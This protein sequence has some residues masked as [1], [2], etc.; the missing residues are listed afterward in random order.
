LFFRVEI[1]LVKSTVGACG[2]GGVTKFNEMP[3]RQL[4]F[5]KFSRNKSSGTITCF[6]SRFS[7]SLTS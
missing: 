6:T 7:S 1:Y 2:S 5:Y 3:Q 4:L